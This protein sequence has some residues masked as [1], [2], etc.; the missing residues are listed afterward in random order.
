ML[1]KDKA[2]LL[3]SGR[4]LSDDQFWFSF[5]HEA[6]HLILHSQEPHIDH[7]STSTPQQETEANGFAQRVILEPEGEAAC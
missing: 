4:F 5:F 3:L 7:E 6:A 2:L 1:E